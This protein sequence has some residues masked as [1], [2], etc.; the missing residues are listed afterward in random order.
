MASQRASSLLNLRCSEFLSWFRSTKLMIPGIE[1]K[2]IYGLV[3]RLASNNGTSV[4]TKS[5]EFGDNI[6]CR[7]V[8]EIH[9]AQGH[10]FRAEDR[11][12]CVQW[13]I[14]IQKNMRFRC[15]MTALYSSI[16]LP[17]FRECI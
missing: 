7:F 10:R 5:A 8:L 3:D 1:S 15:S 12:H 2:I 6:E 14:H 13:E 11:S 17:E 16:L 9:M 4:Q